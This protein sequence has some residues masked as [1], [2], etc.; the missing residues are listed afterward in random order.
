MEIAGDSKPRA[1]F[2]NDATSISIRQ[3]GLK[4][5]EGSTADVKV[6]LRENSPSLPAEGAPAPH[7]DG[8]TTIPCPVFPLVD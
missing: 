3:R 6:A 2:P 5:Q 8:E 4:R 7:Q 1:G